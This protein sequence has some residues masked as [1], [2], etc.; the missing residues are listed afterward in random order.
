MSMTVRPERAGDAAAITEVH[1][2]A[3][4]TPA[5]SRLVELL[6]ADGDLVLSLV[7]VADDGTLIGHVA[8]F[9]LVVETGAASRPAI[10]LAPVAVVPGR[11]RDLAAA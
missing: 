11:E 5:E 7:A 2:L 1:R 3:F 9:R 4:P 6:R 8:F 10:A